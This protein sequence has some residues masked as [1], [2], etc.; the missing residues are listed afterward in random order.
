[1]DYFELDR[2]I[3]LHQHSQNRT[4]TQFDFRF[5]LKFWDSNKLI[6]EKRR[7]GLQTIS[8]QSQRSQN[9]M[10]NLEKHSEK[11]PYLFHNLYHTSSLAHFD[12]MLC[13]RF[14]FRSNWKLIWKNKLKRNYSGVYGMITEPKTN[15]R[16]KIK[17][18]AE[19][20]EQRRSEARR[21]KKVERIR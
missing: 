5:K 11:I 16:N 12:P 1:M 18:E 6:L 20:T 10:R 9:L 7:L 21:L 8:H 17:E 15:I 4:E 2:F 19:N 3:Y 14:R 13:F